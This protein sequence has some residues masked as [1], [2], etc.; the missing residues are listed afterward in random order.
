[1]NL[2]TLT[3]PNDVDTALRTLN[4]A[5]TL[6]GQSADLTDARTALTAL[7]AQLKS[8]DYIVLDP[9]LSGYR[10]V[11]CHFLPDTGLKEYV[12][13]H[14][15]IASVVELAQ[16]LGQ[17][18]VIGSEPLEAWR[19]QAANRLRRAGIVAITDMGED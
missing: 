1:M 17:P 15:R 18:V 14:E 10:Y 2:A 19:E 7:K 5:R 9:D 3:T 16:R 13:G 11:T 8:G 4:D 6:L 12:R